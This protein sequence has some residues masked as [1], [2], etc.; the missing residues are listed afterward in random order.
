M[1]TSCSFLKPLCL[2][3][4]FLLST[5]LLPTPCLV[6]SS[7]WLRSPYWRLAPCLQVLYSTLMPQLWPLALPSGQWS[8]SHLPAGVVLCPDPS[9]SAPGS[10]HKTW[11]PS[12]LPAGVVLCPDPST[13]APGSSHK[14]W[15]P[16]RLPAGVVLYPDAVFPG[17]SDLMN[18][19]RISDLL[20]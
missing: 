8:P 12:H 3:A 18:T 16:S 7:Y 1:L 4:D 11:S 20:E 13:L 6:L 5:N 2:P 10:S 15:S 9:T 19:S 14:T 17:G